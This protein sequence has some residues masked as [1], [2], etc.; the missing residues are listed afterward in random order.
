MASNL[1]TAC[2]ESSGT[3]TCTY[4]AG[5]NTFL[6]PLGV[7]S[8]HVIAVGGKGGQNGW[9]GVEGN[10]NSVGGHG[11]RVEADLV[12]TPGSSLHAVVG[13]NG[14]MD[15]PN[16][17][18]PTDGAGANGGGAGSGN[19]APCYAGGGGGASDLRVDATLPSRLLVAGGGG[20]SGCD[21]RAVFNGET[22][23]G[24]AMGGDAG[25]NGMPQ[26]PVDT[27]HGS[28]G[29]AGC[30][31]SDAIACGA[32]GSAGLDGADGFGVGS[33]GGGGTLGIGGSAVFGYSASG[34]GGGG[35]YFGGGAGGSDG[36]VQGTSGVLC[37]P[38]SGAGGG[39]GSSLVPAGGSLALDATGVP[40]ITISYL[41]PAPAASLD[42]T[43][44]DFGAALI[45]TTT[46][47]Q[48]VTLTNSGI[49]TL[50][51]SV[52]GLIGTNAADFR[53]IANGCSNASLGPGG[54]C[55]TQIAFSP[56]VFGTRT[57]T[58]R[59]TDNASDSP[60]NVALSGFGT[61]PGGDVGVKV[62]AAPG[63]PKIGRTVKYTITVSNAG[64][65]TALGIVVSDGL[66]TQTTFVSATA[67]VGS[68]GAVQAGTVSCTIPSLAVGSKMTIQV[69]VTVTANG[70][71]T[72]AVS[73][74][75]T[76]AD[77]NPTNNTASVTSKVK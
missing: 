70:V 21:G 12:V 13:G 7:S 56:T 29:Q 18:P 68:C 22:Y 32:G 16:G 6:V 8:I 60:Q 45:G 49:A 63:G 64:P 19:F 41:D 24:T 27:S 57:A 20:G 31:D 53:I 37:Q 75:T 26:S 51:V 43:S 2:I 66:P 36:C 77:P 46:A 40:S 73:V 39:G 69:V 1:P 61:V 55:Q 15:N 30:A 50:S 9:Y 23:T 28:G 42:T 11:A 76:T 4:S 52:P 25:A 71:L 58:L 17:T 54:Q 48:T 65:S 38:V 35:G 33:Q 74:A 62:G 47:A 72:N 34:G 67:S 44:I 14:H 59:F 5:D 10:T 3:V